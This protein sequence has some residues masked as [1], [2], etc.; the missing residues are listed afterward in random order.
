VRF[1]VKLF[2]NVDWFSVRHLIIEK[3]LS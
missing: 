3:V 1:L 2:I